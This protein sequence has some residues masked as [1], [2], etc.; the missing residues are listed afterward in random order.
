MRVFLPCKIDPPMLSTYKFAILVREFVIILDNFESRCKF[1]QRHKKSKEANVMKINCYTLKRNLKLKKKEK[2][3]RK[4]RVFAN[5]TGVLNCPL[6]TRLIIR[7][8]MECFFTLTI[9]N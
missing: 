4:A 5:V 1:R 3:R 6:K 2:R 7:L 8:Q 9:G